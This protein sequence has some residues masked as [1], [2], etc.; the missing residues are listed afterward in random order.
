MVTTAD[1][2]KEPKQ[3][4]RLLKSKNMRI[5]SDGNVDS[6]PTGCGARRRPRCCFNEAALGLTLPYRLV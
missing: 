1:S 4:K 2:S 5:G 3:P 6:R